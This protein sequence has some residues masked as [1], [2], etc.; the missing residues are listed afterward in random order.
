MP[1]QASKV[2]IVTGASSGIGLS[3]TERLITRGYTVVMVARTESVLA[4][5]AARLGASAV[6]WPLDVGDL[7]ALALLPEQ[8]VARFGRLDVVVNNAGVNHRGP[9][10]SQP[11]EA[12]AQVVHV[13]LS[14]PI[15]LTRAAVPHLPAGGAVINVASLAGMVPVPEQA[16]Y[17]ASKAGLRAFTAS[18]AAEHPTLR[19][20]VVSPGPVDTGFLADTRRVADIV[21]SQPMSSPDAVAERVMRC[22]DQPSGEEAIPTVSGWLCT[23]GY[24]WPWLLRQLRPLLKKRGAAAKARYIAMLEARGAR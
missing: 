16:T 3:A 4:A 20:S 15:V 1:S 11:A 10:L 18:A 2:A 23:L 7:T 6:A 24:L 5:E 22:L 9:M 12:L 17:G 21:F 14:A 19:I 13:N 8:V